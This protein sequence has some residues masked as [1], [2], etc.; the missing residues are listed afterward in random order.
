MSKTKV[1]TLDQA[2]F[3]LEV[4]LSDLKVR[5]RTIEQWRL[6]GRIPPEPRAYIVSK[7]HQVGLRFDLRVFDQIPRETPLPGKWGD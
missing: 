4:A 2:A 5:R 1:N 7:A 6:R 3:A